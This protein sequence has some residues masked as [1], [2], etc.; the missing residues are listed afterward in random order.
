MIVVKVPKLTMA[1]DGLRGSE[2][3]SEGLSPVNE[4]SKQSDEKPCLSTKYRKI[5]IVL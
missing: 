3:M 4:V 1:S 2:R 5:C